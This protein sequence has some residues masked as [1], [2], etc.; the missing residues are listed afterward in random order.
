[1]G[2]ILNFIGGIFDTIFSGFL[3]II[4]IILLESVVVASRSPKR[5]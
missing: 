2:L 3:W 4:I 1:M 5:R